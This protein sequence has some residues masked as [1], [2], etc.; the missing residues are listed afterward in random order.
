M[1]DHNITRRTI[2]ATAAL[3]PL[4]AIKSA[5]AATSTVFS[6]EQRRTLE[7]FMDRL[8]PKD[9][10]G[11]GASECGAANYI[12]ASLGDFLAAEK[13]AFLDGLNAVD[14]AA[15]SAHE[16]AFAD[17][18]ADQQDA[19]LA[20]VEK[21]SR[22]FFD[23]AR[24]LTLEG[25]FSDPHYGGNTDYRGWDLIRYPGPRL[26]SAPEDQAIKT[27]IKPVRMSAYGG[28]HGH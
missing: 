28:M 27:A 14:A 15:R 21:N 1:S 16:A 9:E 13:P 17:L 8:V 5:A 20:Q 19:V 6:P 10:S 2:V 25:M 22:A 23:R 24:R 7:A 11:P 12:D 18:S 3:V 26:A 4:A